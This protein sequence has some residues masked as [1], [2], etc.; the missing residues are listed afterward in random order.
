MCVHTYVLI[1][2]RIYHLAQILPRIIRF[3]QNQPPSSP[4]AAT[5][6]VPGA[7]PPIATVAAT[8]ISRTRATVPR[9]VSGAGPRHV[10][11]TRAPFW[12]RIL[13]G[14]HQQECPSCF[15]LP[16]EPYSTL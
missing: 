14:G 15:L 9:P 11:A 5:A 16:F 2:I 4:P 6:A 3:A 12:E 8:V 13:C 10:W 1:I 7:G